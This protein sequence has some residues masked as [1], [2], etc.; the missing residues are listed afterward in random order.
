MAGIAPPMFWASLLTVYPGCPGESTPL[1]TDGQAVPLWSCACSLRA[2]SSRW[3]ESSLVIAAASRIFSALLYSDGILSQTSFPVV[4][5]QGLTLSTHL[6]H[7]HVSLCSSK[8]KY[9][10]ICWRWTYTGVLS[11]MVVPFPPVSRLFPLVYKTP[12]WCAA[13]KWAFLTAL[14]VSILKERW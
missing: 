6:Q 3:K 2:S 1:W 13:R 10:P 12:C 5:A 14:F 11:L 7:S 9:H 8:Y 4:T